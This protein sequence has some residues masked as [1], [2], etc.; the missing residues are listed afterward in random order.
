MPATKRVRRRTLGRM[1]WWVKLFSLGPIVGWLGRR[2]LGIGLRRPGLF[3]YPTFKV[4]PVRVGYGRRP[5]VRIR[6]GRVRVR[7]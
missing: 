3:G 2:G 5:A 7:F 6:L 4:G 1:G